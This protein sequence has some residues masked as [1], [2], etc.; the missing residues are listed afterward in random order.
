MTPKRIAIQNY[1]TPNPPNTVRIMRPG[2]GGIL[3]I[4]GSRGWQ[5]PSTNTPNG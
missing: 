2:H 5:K 3:S 1:L 4:G